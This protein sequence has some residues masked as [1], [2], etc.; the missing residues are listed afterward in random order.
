MAENP[1]F[2]NYIPEPSTVVNR[3][4]IIGVII[5][6]VVM[7][8]II[9]IIYLALYN[10]SPNKLASNAINNASGTN[11]QNTSLLLKECKKICDPKG[12]CLGIK[13][14]DRD[15]CIPIIITEAPDFLQAEYHHSVEKKLYKTH[16]ER[17]MLLKNVNDENYV[18]LGK[19]ES[20]L[21][22]KYV[23]HG[24]RIKKNMIHIIDFA[25]KSIKGQYER[26]IFST[27]PF[28]IDVYPYLHSKTSFTFDNLSSEPMNPVGLTLPWDQPPKLWLLIL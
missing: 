14:D 24:V 20:S 13:I 15:N 11:P 12:E 18:F 19:H 25:P 16:P 27:V 1:Y 7:G 10:N 2:V 9:F 28:T 26:I 3:E 4:L 21:N 17:N 5:F 8:V 22:Y 23:M 6:I